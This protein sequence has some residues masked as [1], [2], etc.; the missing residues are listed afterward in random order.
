MFVS[1]NSEKYEWSNYTLVLPAVSVGNVGQLAVDLLLSTLEVVPVGYWYDDCTHPLV[2]CDP[3]VSNYVV[4]NPRLVTGI[5]VYVDAEH[6]LVIFQQRVPIFKHKRREFQKKLIDWIKTEK[7]VKVIMLSSSASHERIDSQLVG[8]PVRFLS[9]AMLDRQLS[10]EKEM[11]WRRLEARV[12]IP[13]LSPLETPAEGSHGTYIPGGGITKRFLE[14]CCQEDIAI[15][16]LLIFCAEG[17]NIPDA[18]L[19]V[20]HLNQWLQLVQ[21]EEAQNPLSLWKI[22]PS[23]QLMFGSAAPPAMF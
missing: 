9:S 20:R 7:F 6:Q 12:C 14:K 22:P 16:V 18:L 19:L 10:L 3:F 15:A 11:S 4:Q 8:T 23:W 2:G 13:A 1:S 5:E 21:C 17:D